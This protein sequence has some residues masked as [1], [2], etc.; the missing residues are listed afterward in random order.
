MNTCKIVEADLESLLKPMLE[1]VMTDL[2]KRVLDCIKEELSKSQNPPSTSSSKVSIDL[3]APG[4]L[5][6]DEN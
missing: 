5:A 2:E 6:R 4:A 1:K 3:P